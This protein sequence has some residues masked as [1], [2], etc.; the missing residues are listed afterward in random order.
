MA[1]TVG[2]WEMV[3]VDWEK[4]VGEGSAMKDGWEKGEIECSESVI[5][6]FQKE[7][8]IGKEGWVANLIVGAMPKR[9]TVFMN[10]MAQDRSI[11]RVGHVGGHNDKRRFLPSQSRF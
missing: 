4:G 5:T 6:W 7:A 10:L 8:L 9:S 2:E 3:G 1:G 11:E